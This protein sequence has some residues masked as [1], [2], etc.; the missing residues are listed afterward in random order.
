MKSIIKK[1][2]FEIIFIP[3]MLASLI[4]SAVLFHSAPMILILTILGM[5]GSILNGRGNKLCYIFALISTVMYGMVSLEAN[6]IGEAIL[7]FAFLSPMYIFS[8]LK[9]LKPKKIGKTKNKQMFSLNVPQIVFIIVAGVIVVGVYG[10]ILKFVIKSSFPFLNAVSTV[11]VLL[12][13][14]LGAKRVKEQWVAHILGNVV[15]IALWV[16]SGDKGNYPILIQNV[17]FIICNVRG[18]IIWR[19]EAKKQNPK[20]IEPNDD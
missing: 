13:A 5:V 2:L 8:I 19:K 7:H 4:T 9:W 14:Y 18:I 10:T 17:L 6:Y 3:V 20:P 11:A 16:L 1:N 12:A 15:L